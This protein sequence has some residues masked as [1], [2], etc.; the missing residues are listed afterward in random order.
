M[1]QAL[2]ILYSFRR[3]PYAMRARMALSVSGQALEHREVDL[4][5]RPEE[6]IAVS[7]K[8]TVP[9]VVLADGTV[10]EESIDV[11]R[12]ALTQHDPE[13]WLPATEEDRAT[14]EALIA[15]NDGDFK[16]HLDRY[17][18]A[19][20]YEDVDPLEHR[21]AASAIL[22]ELDQRLQAGPYLLGDRFTFADAALA[23]FVRQFAFAD[24]AWFDAQPWPALQQ[25]LESFLSSERFLG[26]M[27]K[28][29][30]WAADASGA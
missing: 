5:Q 19:T 7:P 29:P 1:S 14:T 6:L 28:H 27:Q 12:W 23:P 18:Y 4:K 9:V 25:W 13:G 30:V 26:I 17:K 10:L 24:K 11:M 22:S 8:A 2:P 20:R 15:R 3:C 21:T 16:K